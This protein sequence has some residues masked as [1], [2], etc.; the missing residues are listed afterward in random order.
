M[1]SS[2]AGSGINP[3]QLHNLASD[4]EDQQQPLLSP[5]P[6]VNS[7]YENYFLSNSN[8]GRICDEL[9]I[10]YQQQQQQSS[11][12]AGIPSSSMPLLT[13]SDYQFAEQNNQSDSDPME[14]EQPFPDLWSWETWRY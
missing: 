9:M 6:A 10:D 7:D 14:M 13:P 12:S 4:Q 3:M 5:L 8:V 1:I 11:S 2:E